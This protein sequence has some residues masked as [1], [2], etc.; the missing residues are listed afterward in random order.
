[1]FAF[2]G[3]EHFDVVHWLVVVCLQTMRS[4]D[5]L[6]DVL[7]GF[8]GPAPHPSS[9]RVCGSWFGLRR[10]RPRSTAFSACSSFA[11]RVTCLRDSTE[12]VQYAAPAL[13]V[14]VF[15]PSSLDPS[16]KSRRQVAYPANVPSLSSPYTT[17]MFVAQFVF[18]IETP[19]RHPR[20]NDRASVARA[21][22][23]LTRSQRFC[24]VI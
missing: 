19:S 22:T 23:C 1:M 2:R 4:E 21:D 18:L 5:V 6:S 7:T 8:V 10:D 17:I 14:F 3:I 16:D 9:T 24:C 20:C 15:S 13:G 11:S 12:P